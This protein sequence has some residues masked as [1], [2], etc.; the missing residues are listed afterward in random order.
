MSETN[1]IVVVYRSHS[2]AEAGVKE[3]QRAGFD[4]KKLSTLGKE[5][6]VAGPSVV[7]VGLHSLG[8][9]KNSILRYESAL[10]ADKFLLLAHGTAEE[11]IQAKDILRPT[12]PEEVSVHLAEESRLN[13]A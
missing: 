8:I 2:D 13:A 4:M 6:L 7:G 5:C 3:L 12:Q 10:A 11:V 9:A 1:S